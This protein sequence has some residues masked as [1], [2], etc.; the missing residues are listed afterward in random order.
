MID[1]PHKWIDGQNAPL[2]ENAA[3]SAD[4]ESALP[5][6]KRSALRETRGAPAQDPPGDGFKQPANA[7]AS[8]NRSN[9]LR[10]SVCACCHVSQMVS[11]VPLAPIRS[12]LL[13]PTIASSMV[14]ERCAH[15]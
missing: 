11:A 12:R 3:R 1:R 10:E 2:L 6:N 5:P 7:A 4:F 15:I 8:N 14:L 13:A 9:L